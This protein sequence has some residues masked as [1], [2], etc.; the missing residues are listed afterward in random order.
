MPAE[1]EVEPGGADFW[2]GVDELRPLRF[3]GAIKNVKGTV[4][5][6]CPL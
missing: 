4:I 2:A 5:H 6:A 3:R 1:L